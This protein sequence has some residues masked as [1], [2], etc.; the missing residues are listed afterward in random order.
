ML[1]VVPPYVVLA[2]ELYNYAQYTHPKYP[3][4]HRDAGDYVLGVLEAVLFAP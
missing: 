4:V 2:I 3:P 1:W